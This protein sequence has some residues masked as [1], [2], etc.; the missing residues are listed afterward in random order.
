MKGSKLILASGSMVKKNELKIIVIVA[1]SWTMVDFALFMIRKYSNLL[2]LKYSDPLVNIGRAI[3][4]REV[5]V[6]LVSLIIGFLL[7]SVLKK[8]LRDSSLW[9]N[10]FVKTLILVSVA[11][12]MNFIIYVSYEVLIHKKAFNIVLN[13][14]LTNTFRAEWFL[15]KMTEWLILFMVTSLAL[16]INEKYSRGVFFISCWANICSQKKKPASSCLLI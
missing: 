8:F 14:F 5:E 13:H 12:I 10:L 15:P 9:F 3:L 6:M 4:L 7:V 11:I 2:P 16:E 1:L